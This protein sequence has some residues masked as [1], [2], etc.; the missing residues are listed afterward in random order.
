MAQFAAGESAEGEKTCWDLVPVWISFFAKKSEGFD[1]A[2]LSLS[3]PPSLC[4]RIE[5]PSA[6]RLPLCALSPS[7]LLSVSLPLSLSLLPPIRILCSMRTTEREVLRERERARESERG[8]ARGRGREARER[9]AGEG[10][11]GERERERE[12]LVGGQGTV[13]LE[14]S[15]ALPSHRA[16][17]GEAYSHPCL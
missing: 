10:E 13:S 14:V 5:L 15:C 17:W 7:L 12:R 2:S 11:R 3:L 8:G 16:N 9:G 6:R 1:K 4:P